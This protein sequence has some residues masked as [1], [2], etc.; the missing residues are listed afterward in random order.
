MCLLVMNYFSLCMS[1]KRLYF[2]S[3]FVLLFDEDVVVSFGLFL[4]TWPHIWKIVLP[5]IE[6][7]VGVFFVLFFLL[8]V[9]LYCSLF[10]TLITLSSSVH[11]FWQ[12]FVVSLSFF[13]FLWIMYCLFIHPALVAFTIF[14]FI[15]AAAAAAKSLQLCLTLCDP[16]VGSP[17][18]SP[19]PGI[20]Q[21]R[22]LEW[23][24]IA[25]SVFIT[26]LEQ[27]DYSVPLCSLLHICCPKF[28]LNFLDVWV[29]NFHCL[30]M[31]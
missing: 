23:V 16:R 29:H 27:F 17:P 26:S 11:C 22:T 31:F 3:F 5:G 1:E 2:T 6:V 21:A 19:V 20:L 13:F 28:S 14:F 24:A 12:D 7:W 18:G 25:F 30:E 9:V 10:I 8:Y 4:N 15:T